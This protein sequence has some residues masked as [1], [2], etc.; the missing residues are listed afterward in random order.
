[1]MKKIYSV[2]S[3]LLTIIL[4]GVFV[5]CERDKEVML[6]AVS[7]TNEQITPM[8]K[9]A[10]ISSTIS[11]EATI[12]DVFVQYTVTKDFAEYDEVP[13]QEKDGIYTAELIDLLDNTTYYYRY[14]ASNRHSAIV[15]QKIQQFATLQPTVPAIRLDSI[16]T[17]WDSY[18]QVQVA[19]EFDGG[20]SVTDMGVCWGTQA[21]PTIEDIHKS[22]KDT[23]AV[24]DIPSLQPN[25]QYYVRAYAVNKV[26]VAYSEELVFTTYALPEVR[27]E[28]V[29][30]IQVNTALLSA[31]LLFDGNDTATIKGFCWSE[32]SEP[33]IEGDHIAIDT[34]SAGYT[35][36]LTALLSETQYFV[37]AYAQNKIGIVYGEEK[38]FTTNK[39][40]VLPSVTTTAIT[41]I[42]ETSAVAGGNVTSDGNATVTER[43][44][45]YGIKQN[46]T[47]D[48]NKLTSDSG[49]G[50][51]TCNL[52]DLQPNTIYYVRAYATNE[53]GT[54]YGEE[55]NFTTSKQIVLPTVTTSAV[56]QITE[57]TAVAGGNVTSDGNATVTERGVVYSTKQNPTI[58]DNKKLNGSGVGSFVC[59]LSNLQPNTTYYVRAYATNEKGTAYGELLKFTTSKQIVL[60]TVTTNAVTQITETTAVAGGNVTADGNAT[61]TE[62]G[63]VYATTP[64]P[65]T[66]NN[67]VSGGTGTGSYTC[68]LIDLQPN[69][70]YYV[71]AYAINS[72]GTTYGEEVT[73][74]TLVPIVLPTLTTSSVTQIT[75]TTAVVGGNVT[76]DGGASVTERG[77]VYATTQNPTINNTKVT[78]GIGTGSFTCNLTGLQPNTTYYV[79]AYATNEVGTAYGEEMSFTTEEQVSISDPTGTEN[80]Y[81]YVDL[82][83]SVK[84]ASYNIGATKPE[85]YG[86]YFAWGEVEPKD[87]YDW[88]TYK[89]CNGSYRSLTK[90]NTSN[91][92]GSIDN[93]TQLE[94]TDDAAHVN[95]GG[96]WRMPTDE[97]MAELCEQCTWIWTNQNGVKG[98]KV[99]SKNNG[100]CIFLSASGFRDDSLLS[101]IDN[102][103][104][105]SSSLGTDR[106]DNAWFIHFYSSN[107][108]ISWVCSRCHGQSVRPVLGENEVEVTTPTVT[109]PTVTQ[110]T[111]TTAVA[112]GNVTSDGGASVTERGVV[113]ATTQ[114]PTINNTKVTSGIGTGS[115]TCNLTG[116]QPNTTYYVRAYA[117]N[118]VGIAYGEEVSFMT[119]EEI[120]DNPP[121][122]LT[123]MPFSVSESKQVYF[124][125]GNLQYHPANDEWRFAPSQLDYI[126][127]ANSNGS[128]TYNGWLDLF[129]WSTSANNFGV[130]TST[131]NNDYSGSFV[132]WGT[133]N[134]GSD[135]P[136]TWRTLT[137]NEWEYLLETRPNASS[138]CGVAQV[139]GVNGLIF[140]PD[141]WICPAGITFKSGFHIASGPDNYADYQT[142]T[143]EQWSKLEAAGAVFLPAAGSRYGTLV[144]YVQD[145]GKYYS[146]A[147]EYGSDDANSLGFASDVAGVG[148]Y[149][150]C[151]GR[152]VRLVKDLQQET[153]KSLPSVTTAAITQIT[154]TTAVAGGNVTNDGGAQVTERGVVYSTNP[155]PVITNLN[156]TI[157]PCGSGTGAFT[158]NMTGLQSGTTYYVRAYAKNDVGTAYGEEVSFTTKEESSTPSNGTENGHEYIDLGLSVKWA[159]CNVG[160]SSPEEYGDYYAWGETT[161]K[162]EYNWS[163]YKYCYTYYNNLTKYNTYSSYGTVDNKT[164]LELGD[165]AAR[166]KLGGAWRLPTEAEL[167]ELREQCTWTWTTQNGVNGY[168]VTS[169]SNG[170]NIF[171]PAAGYRMD[172]KL[173]V[174]G[175]DGCYWAN[176]ISSNLPYCAWRLDFNASEVK[177]NGDNRC[178]GQSV[179]PVCP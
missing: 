168:K 26:G 164:T 39:S 121:S 57:T 14:A 177:W 7:I 18:A 145:E 15:L 60:P 72:K 127:D 37:R 71:R 130:S 112:G 110:I 74:T 105:W 149:Y 126:G 51:F 34:A 10:T 52:T 58:S 159:T 167:L 90:Y 33:T 136:N 63:V 138:L 116:L 169:K 99:I 69:M 97:E 24:L 156:N 23:V 96:A 65:T 77:V 53:K 155:N 179:R 36:A 101:N 35:Y 117:I 125:K 160:A 79:R 129:G 148:R 100:N 44:V 25:T 13:M 61:V 123:A 91:T 75:E 176:S 137:R 76:S 81:G 131:D 115:F 173:K 1:M 85:E 104:Y 114:N 22:T 95:W 102:G 153:V 107:A 16:L 166:A 50:E 119:V 78:S 82:G 48:D 134:I 140:L 120:V 93:K 174:V 161:T 62:R 8:Y 152:S 157:R 87:C 109:T 66:A 67:K 178:Y 59:D 151:D 12:R 128:S 5:S 3:V 55:L 45:V 80:G 111:E 32:K 86:D 4:M 146:S 175:S 6:T 108:S 98:Y 139:H 158:Y 2:L 142:F 84:W 135:T 31:T 172:S 9:S 70:T 154:E 165:D 150:R 132:D 89:Y 20:A 54:A 162:T 170:N 94:L 27:T 92:Y 38:S 118:S 113:Y 73:F 163:T 106:P 28:E 83:L 144:N 124:S 143:V 141:N 42:T 122:N 43:G 49:T 68:N 11:S 64:N 133:N 103:Y 171:L 30:D 17:V 29:A 147:T 21:N 56:T 46:P 40:V 88:S 19:L 41:K 47:T